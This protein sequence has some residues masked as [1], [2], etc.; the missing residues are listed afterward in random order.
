MEVHADCETCLHAL[1]SRCNLQRRMDFVVT[2]GEG[3]E[4]PQGRAQW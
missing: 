4:S 2:Q 1:V 3:A